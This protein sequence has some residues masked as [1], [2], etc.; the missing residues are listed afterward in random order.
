MVFSALTWMLQSAPEG[1]LV[2]VLEVFKSV[3]ESVE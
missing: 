3:V 2:T 1:M